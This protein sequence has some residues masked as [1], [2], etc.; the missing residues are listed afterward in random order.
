MGKTVSD[1]AEGEEG[2]K[3]ESRT[4]LN[5]TVGELAEGTGPAALSGGFVGVHI[6]LYESGRSAVSTA[7]LGRGGKGGC[8]EAAPEVCTRGLNRATRQS[9]HILRRPA[10]RRH[11]RLDAAAHRA[12]YLPLPRC[13]STLHSLPSLPLLC[14]PARSP[15]LRHDR[16]PLGVRR[17]AARASWRKS[18]VLARRGTSRVEV[19]GVGGWREGGVRW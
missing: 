7:A 9:R 14:T 2:E 15:P 4:N 12:N 5:A 3:G 19:G 16:A 10:H 11:P 8:F 1:C 13:S 17:R 6:D 18:P